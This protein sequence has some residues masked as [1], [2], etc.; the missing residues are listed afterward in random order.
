MCLEGWINHRTIGT[1]I[2][3]DPLCGQVCNEPCV[4]VSNH[5]K[6]DTE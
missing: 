4:A 2:I 5:I 3:D 1:V 6:Y